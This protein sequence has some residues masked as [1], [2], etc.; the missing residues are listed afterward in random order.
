MLVRQRNIDVRYVILCLQLRVDRR[1]CF[2][3]IRLLRN[4][5]SSSFDCVECGKTVFAIVEFGN[6]KVEGGLLRLCSDCVRD[7]MR[8]VE[9]SGCYR[10]GKFVAYE[11]GK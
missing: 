8:E 11:E 2:L 3:A 4:K 9:S 10:G 5:E 6:V 1:G 7:G